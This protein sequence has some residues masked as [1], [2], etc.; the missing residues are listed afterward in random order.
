[1]AINIPFAMHIVNRHTYNRVVRFFR[2]LRCRR[3][4]NI[5]ML[6]YN[7]STMFISCACIE[8]VQIEIKLLK[9][10]KIEPLFYAFIWPWMLKWIKFTHFTWHKSDKNSFSFFLSLSHQ[11]LDLQFITPW[12]PRAQI[13]KCA[14]ENY[15]C[16]SVDIKMCI[17]CSRWAITF[18]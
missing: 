1:M 16:N 14:N 15:N 2:L 10:G 12:I 8:S 3:R 11:L 9:H 4:C 17:P 13:L 18:P 5:K 6:T 7:V